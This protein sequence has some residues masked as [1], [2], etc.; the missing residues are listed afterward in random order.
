MR[1]RE[2][3]PGLPPGTL[4]YIGDNQDVKTS[5]TLFD[6][7]GESLEEL[8][9]GEPEKLQSYLAENRVSWSNINGLTDVDTIKKI[10]EIFEIHPLVL[11]DIVNT[12]HRPKFEDYGKY[13]FSVVK[14]LTYDVKNNELNSEQVS[15]IIGDN[16][17]LTFQE[18]EGDVFD[19]IR[20]RLRRNKGRVRREKADYLFYTLIDA[21]VDNY[22]N[23]LEYIAE[24][25]EQLEEL[26]LN[27]ADTSVLQ[28]IHRLKRD[29]IFMRKSVWPLREVLNN[30][31]RLE[32]DLVRDSTKLF[33]RDVYDHTIQIIDT[34]EN[35]RDIVTGM[36]DIYLST[37]SNRMNEVMKV[38]TIIATIFIPLTFIAGVYGMNFQYMPELDWKFGYP[39]ILGVMVLLGLGMMLFF[40]RKKWL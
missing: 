35:L 16:Y 32:P 21:I 5:I 18:I 11:E 30:I 4:I 6:Y 15:F 23:T 27:D 33:F 25:T 37:V 2:K 34:I 39:L 22:F 24:E 19:T 20:E 13:Y 1:K 31:D 28:R 7:D 17:L 9:I 12:D 38:L 8:T 26:L 40:R 14:M 36:L 29:L 10:G 3:K